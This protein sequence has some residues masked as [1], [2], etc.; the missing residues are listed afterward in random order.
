MIPRHIMDEDEF[1]FF[2]WE[3]CVRNWFALGH[4]YR[5]QYFTNSALRDQ[6]TEPIQFVHYTFG[7]PFYYKE[8]HLFIRSP[9]IWIPSRN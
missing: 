6:H 2:I 5:C 1:R 4:P 8:I 9:W 7:W 3:M